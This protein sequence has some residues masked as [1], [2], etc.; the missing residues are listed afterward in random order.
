[1]KV[2]L[3]WLALPVFALALT[4]LFWTAVGN[5][6][7]FAKHVAK[8]KTVHSSIYAV[9]EAVT[10]DG[11]VEGDVFCAAQ[12]VTISGTV[13][14]DVL[15]AGRDVKVS[16]TVTGSIRAA[17]QEVQLD[18]AKVSHAVTLAGQKITVNKESIVGQDATLAGD[19]TELL[20]RIGRDATIASGTLSQ[21]GGNIG[22]NVQFNG[23]ELELTDDAVVKGKVTYSSDQMISKGDNIA[24]A[25]GIEHHEPQQKK[26]DFTS[27]ILDMLGVLVTFVVFSMV[28]VLLLPR[29]THKVSEIASKNLLKSMLAGF[30]AL[31][32][33]PAA[34]IALFISTIGIPL[35]VLVLLLGIVL[36][37]LSGP[38]AAYYLGRL[39]LAKT[40]NPLYFMLLGSVV[41]GLLVYAPVL[42]GLVLFVAYILGSGAILLSAKRHWPQPEYK[43]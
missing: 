32:A 18:G 13:K 2:R 7:S 39:L 28:L 23:G 5:A 6:Q 9:G 25:G 38:V 33:F 16:G 27:G 22:R 14:G 42:G 24:V 29:L 36:A 17:G 11:T 34:I 40:K 12:R 20:G 35:A 31:F 10:I 30:V 15:C 8:D 3:K 43:V 4:G 21:V 19:E 41:L 1:M 37:M 26:E